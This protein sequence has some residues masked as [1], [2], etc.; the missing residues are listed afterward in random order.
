[1][2]RTFLRQCKVV[3]QERV[4]DRQQSNG[5]TLQIPEVFY[6]EELLC[7]WRTTFQTRKC[8]FDLKYL[9]HKSANG[10]Q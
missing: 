7:S 9:Q 10:E 3:P 5:Q 6:F 4:R 1:M 2:F 8:S